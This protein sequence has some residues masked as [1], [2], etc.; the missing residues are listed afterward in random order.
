[1]M[2][3]F[4]SGLAGVLAVALLSQ[5]TAQPPGGRTKEEPTKDTKKDYSES[6]IVVKM[7][8]FNKKKDGKLTRDEVTDEPLQ[9]GLFDQADTNKDGVVT[10]DELIMLAAKI[11]R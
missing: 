10:K 4:Y 2:K 9:S 7:M 8:A 5:A 1:M 11:R 3:L 6:P